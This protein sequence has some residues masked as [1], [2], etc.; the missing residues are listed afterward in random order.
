MVIVTKHSDGLSPLVRQLGPAHLTAPVDRPPDAGVGRPDRVDHPRVEE[1]Q[2][3]NG[4]QIEKEKRYLVNRI[5]LIRTDDV[6]N[7][8]REAP[9][10]G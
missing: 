9:T 4:N 7:I 1:Y 10:L 5:I 6:F 2:K 3:E 8:S